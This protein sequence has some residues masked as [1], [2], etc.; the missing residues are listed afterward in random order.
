ML[1]LNDHRAD[2]DFLDEESGIMEI[3]DKEG[4]NLSAHNSSHWFMMVLEN[5]DDLVLS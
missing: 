4:F 2:Q 3:E 1:D 5:M